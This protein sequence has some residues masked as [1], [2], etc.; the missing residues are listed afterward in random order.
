M[1]PGRW[2]AREGQNID[3]SAEADNVSNKIQIVYHLL[4]WFNNLFALFAIDTI[5]ALLEIK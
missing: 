3:R 5:S 1:G 2:S 4:A